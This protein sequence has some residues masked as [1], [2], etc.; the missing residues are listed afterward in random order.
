MNKFLISVYL[1]IFFLIGCVQQEPVG[2]RVTTGRFTGDS[3]SLKYPNNLQQLSIGSPISILPLEISG[4]IKSCAIKYGTASLPAGLAIDSN[5][6]ISGTPALLSPSYKYIVTAMTEYNTAVDA[7]VSIIVGTFYN[8]SGTVAGLKTGETVTITNNGIDP[9]IMTSNTTF[10]FPYVGSGTNYNIEVVESNSSRFDCSINNGTG[11]V[12]MNVSGVEV[13]CSSIGS[14]NL[15]GNLSG[16]RAIDGSVTLQNNGAQDII[17]LDNGSFDFG[18][19]PVDSN[20]NITVQNSPVGYVCNLVNGSGVLSDDISNVQVNCTPPEPK[21]ITVKVT[22][23]NANSFTIKNAITKNDGVAYTESLTVN[24]SGLFTFVEKSKHNS[25]YT[26][27]IF[28]QPA[29]HT[30]S[31]VNGTGVALNDVENIEINCTANTYSVGGTISGLG[32]GD[33]LKFYFNDENGPTE[34]THEYNT[35]GNTY[36]LP[37]QFEFNRQF[38]IVL[39]E[40]PANKK[41]Y[42]GASFNSSSGSTQGFVSSHV[43][44]ANITCVPREVSA[45]EFGHHNYGYPTGMVKDLLCMGD[46]LYVAGTFKGHAYQ[47]GSFVQLNSDL[48][49]DYKQS[50]KVEGGVVSAVVDDGEGSFYIAG[51]F[52]KVN[53]ENRGGL[54]KIFYDGSLDKNFNPTVIGQVRSL[55]L[56]KNFLFVGGYF[57]TIAGS[58]RS[59]FAKIHRNTGQ[60]Q[61]LN[62]S[63]N[64]YVYSMV[65]RNSRL[66]IAGNFTTIYGSAVRNCLAEIDIDSGTL[67]DLAPTFTGACNVYTLAKDSSNNVYVGGNFINVFNNIGVN[68]L[69]KLNDQNQVDLAYFKSNNSPNYHVYSLRLVTESSQ[70]KLIVGGGFSSIFGSSSSYLAKINIDDSQNIFKETL[71][72]PSSNYILSMAEDNDYLYTLSGNGQILK[73]LKG[74]INP[75]AVAAVEY[76]NASLFSFVGFVNNNFFVSRNYS[77]TSGASYSEINPYLARYDL[78]T[79]R[80]DSTFDLN[81]NSEVSSLQK[82]NQSLFVAGSFTSV[83]GQAKKY[84]VSVDV[85]GAP[86]LDS[87]FNPVLNLAVEKIIL[88]SSGFITLGNFTTVDSNTGRKYLVLLDKVDGSY[89]NSVDN[90]TF[91]SKPA[92]IVTDG[93]SLYVL[94][95]GG[96]SVHKYGIGS[97]FSLDSTFI[98]GV[99]ANISTMSYKDNYLYLKSS[100]SSAIT[101]PSSLNN[102]YLL[103]VDA[104][105]GSYDST[106]NTASLSYYMYGISILESTGQYLYTSYSY[107][108]RKIKLSDGSAASYSPAGIQS[109]SYAIPNQYIEGSNFLIIGGSFGA[110]GKTPTANLVMLDK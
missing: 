40:V 84:L 7:E 73:Y 4:K 70:E 90:T 15:R 102:R 54:A 35:D 31:L 27:S 30:C 61:T 67:S 55:H 9:I 107:S 18:N 42:F 52:T 29:E 71:N 49:S 74:D 5:C 46:Y 6:K 12:N 59:N 83:L 23:L 13:I 65:Q 93:A 25:N 78:K 68:H 53:G 45:C 100:S 79:G 72:N 63:L 66:M 94:K 75:Q 51:S 60:V 87:L 98:S 11:L 36:S 47:S 28:T 91:T 88:T 32:S 19:L 38:R 97:N 3:V 22:G 96:S 21:K 85:S 103:R 69:F 82:D 105:T 80:I 44:N 58:A 34:I 10:T 50:L 104:T 14:R 39:T 99:T 57:N 33:V 106:F 89:V 8:V 62:L 92:S 1:I 2:D 101:Y 16:L 77:E 17:K 109:D 24:S 56:Y 86:Q 110:S 81:L 43:S 41:C 48:R 20:Y 95:S 108:F 37:R 26:V 76:P 64:G